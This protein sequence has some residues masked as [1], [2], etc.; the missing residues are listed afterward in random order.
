MAAVTPAVSATTTDTNVSLTT[1]P[2]TPATNDLI[3]IFVV[4]TG[5]VG[6]PVITDTQSLDW[7][8]AGI[9]AEDTNNNASLY[10]FIAENLAAN[11]SL[12]ITVN[13][14]SGTST[15][16]A[17]SA[18]RVSGM[19]RTGL[20]SGGALN[21]VKQYDNRNTQGTG[22]PSINFLFNNPSAAGDPII[23]A[24]ANIANPAGM[25][26]PTNYTEQHDIG[27]DTP[28]T[29]LNVC[30]VDD[31]DGLYEAVYGNSTDSWCAL[32]INLD[33]RAF[34]IHADLPSAALDIAG[35]AATTP[36]IAPL[37]AA[38]LDLTSITATTRKSVTSTIASLDLTG[39]AAGAN[40]STSLNPGLLRLTPIVATATKAIAAS[41]ALL[42]LLAVAATINIRPA[43]PVVALDLL[44]VAPTTTKAVAFPADVINVMAVTPTAQHSISVSAVSLL[45]I[46]VS[47]TATKQAASTIA[48]V[49]ITG[50]AATTLLPTAPIVVMELLAVAPEAAGNNVPGLALL[51]I[52]SVSTVVSHA[53]SAGQG[54][55]DILAPATTHAKS[56]PAPAVNVDLTSVSPTSTHTS[57]LS[58]VEL[59]LSDVLPTPATHKNITLTPLV[60]DLTN[61]FTDVPRLNLLPTSSLEVNVLASP[62]TTK[63]ITHTIAEIIVT[64]LAPSTT[65]VTTL[66]A[67]RMNTRAP[68]STAT[69]RATLGN[70]QITFTP[71]SPSSSKEAASGQA[72]LDLTNPATAAMRTAALGSGSIDVLGI[73]PAISKGAAL[74]I[75]LVDI[76]APGYYG[77]L[78]PGLSAIRGHLR[79]VCDVFPIGNDFDLEWHGAEFNNDDS[80]V[81]TAN[82]VT[83]EAW[84]EDDDGDGSQNVAYLLP[85][86]IVTPVYDSTN[87]CWR[88]TFPS[89]LE[90]T[91]G[92]YYRI[93]MRLVSTSP[94]A[95]GVRMIRRQARFPE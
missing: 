12:E 64:P 1:D 48:L 59:L 5:G 83:A 87:D 65:K 78:A 27:Y 23:V 94:S 32:L 44:S 69:L 6:T 15:G 84:I 57:T 43:Q 50:V 71:R 49:D 40:L 30:A 95:R 17:I 63:A 56:V 61:P 73:T 91:E 47:P 79:M 28:T 70:D 41:P 60:I 51:D 14:A 37:P 36:T 81:T 53:A 76:F 58:A 55:L 90:P 33:S 86:S 93:F 45:L 26:T 77:I 8:H 54:L 13:P 19:Q 11:S 52:V 67:V 72:L 75:G 24:L 89:S 31:G 85:G 4:V 25:T 20:E 2:F 7:G 38:A 82:V 74:L 35:I 66:S 92:D 68:V 29:G 42:D 46:P 3:V 21:A 88:A 22:T 62:T 80:S 34:G 10:L 18:L 16:I 9:V 39:V